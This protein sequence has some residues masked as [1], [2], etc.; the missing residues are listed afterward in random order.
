M[1]F[2]QPLDPVRN[3]RCNLQFAVEHGTGI[4]SQ[5]LL[6]PDVVGY[7]TLSTDIGKECQP[8]ESYGEYGDHES[9]PALLCGWRRCDRRVCNSL[10]Y[11]GLICERNDSGHFAYIQLL[12]PGYFCKTAAACGKIFSNMIQAINNVSARFNVCP[13]T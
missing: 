8:D 2:L 1:R 9:H 10:D 13:H 12:V 6:M 7:E 3:G 4:N 11:D 5:S